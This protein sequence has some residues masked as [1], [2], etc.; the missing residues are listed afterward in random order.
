MYCVRLLFRT[1]RIV[2][3]C[4]ASRCTATWWFF[5]T[6]VDQEVLCY[7]GGPGSHT[8]CDLQ[9]PGSFRFL[10]ETDGDRATQVTLVIPW[11]A[12]AD[13]EMIF[14][15][16]QSFETPEAQEQFVR[17]W[18]RKRTGMPCNFKVQCPA[19]ML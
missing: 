14:P 8:A 5:V 7:G 12:P 6:A 19:A 18:A 13:Q 11:L 9:C 16:N 15:N 1:T 2:W 4:C 17:A 10:S 3:F